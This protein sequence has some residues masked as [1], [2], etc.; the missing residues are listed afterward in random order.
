MSK[1]L[2]M[3]SLCHI[4]LVDLGQRFLCNLAVITKRAAQGKPSEHFAI[5]SRL[6]ILWPRS[7][8]PLIVLSAEETLL[9]RVYSVLWHL[10]LWLEKPIV[11]IWNGITRLALESRRNIW[12]AAMLRSDNVET[13]SRDAEEIHEKLTLLPSG[14][15]QDGL[16]SSSLVVRVQWP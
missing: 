3:F 16:T 14:E 7:S 6:E 9:S 12:V 8:P 1:S 11:L 10:W 2:E 5:K 15:T 13:G 4:P